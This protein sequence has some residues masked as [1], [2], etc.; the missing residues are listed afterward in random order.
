M[1]QV[2]KFD[3]HD[4]LRST[5][6]YSH[7][8]VVSSAVRHMQ[9]DIPGVRNTGDGS[10]GKRHHD[11]AVPFRTE[12]A[13]QSKSRVTVHGAPVDL[14]GYHQVVTLPD[15][16]GRDNITGEYRTTD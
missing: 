7:Q 14:R 5:V 13:G 16:D 11:H 2:A 8:I 1:L 6:Q 4:L 10:G 15:T 9:P 12:H 3:A